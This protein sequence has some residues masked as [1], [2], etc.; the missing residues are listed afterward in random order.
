VRVYGGAQDITERK[1]ATEKSRRYAQQL[2]ALRQVGLELTVELE[3]DTLLRSIVSH[4]IKLLHASAGGIDLYRP[5][6]DVLEWVVSIG[7]EL[8][9]FATVL[10]RGEGLCGKVWQ[11]DE[12]VIVDD[13]PNWPGRVA[14][15]K[16]YS[17]TAVIGVPVRWGNQFLGVLAVMAEPSR[18][19]S[20]ADARLLEMFATQA[21]IAIQN[22]RL[23]EQL[24]LYTADLEARVAERT[25]E[26]AQVNEQLKELDRLKSKFIS[27]VSHELRTPITNL[28]LYLDLLELGHS[29]K[30]QE[31]MN[32]LRYQ[33]ARLKQLTEDVLDLS[34][35]QLDKERLVFGPVDL[36]AEVME[37]MTT[38]RPRAKTAGLTLVFEADESL[39]PVKGER[40]RL[41]QV[42]TNLV[43]N[44]I[45]YT[46][47][48]HI[49]ICTYW[50]RERKR[51][52]L[53][54]E[55][56]G[57]GIDSI[58]RLHLFERFYRGRHVS[59]LNIPGTG[60]GLAIAKE[61]VDLH[62]GQIEVQSEVGQGSTF[63]V[64][65]PLE[66]Q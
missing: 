51:A 50:D 63:K 46:R 64:W 9:E 29:D 53:V 10:Q 13:Y 28:A 19:F 17:W 61:I 5:E 8:P 34:R 58:D 22:A 43:A 45:N 36:N 48:G 33:S 30:Q 25:R 56:T 52:C 40:G 23:Y 66:E 6:Q 11:R 15:D 1:R 60:L 44:A 3:L 42:V 57:V 59:Q 18:T 49:R 24:R 27:D 31:Y 65:L 47:E 7:A 2:E 32:V 39:P 37:V 38:Q 4:A 62:G 12:P 54:V 20:Q 26:L 55:D 16:N 35:L 41:A 14:I 21:A